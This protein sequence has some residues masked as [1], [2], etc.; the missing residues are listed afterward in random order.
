MAIHTETSSESFSS[1]TRDS[2]QEFESATNAGIQEF[3][4][5][6]ENRF[7]SDAGA[8]SEMF[9]YHNAE[10]TKNVIRRVEKILSSLDTSPREIALG[11][12]FA[13]AHDTIQTGWINPRSGKGKLASGEFTSIFQRYSGSNE[14]TSFEELSQWMLDYN[15]KNGNQI[16]SDVDIALAKE[17]ITGTIPGFDDEKTL[18]QPE[19][20]QGVSEIT[21]ALA[22]ADL[23]A[24]GMEGP[25][26]LLN[27]G[28]A[29]FREEFFAISKTL[30]DPE[31]RQS[32]TENQKKDIQT[33]MVEWSQFQIAIANGFKVTFEKD[34]LPLLNE[35]K[36]TKLKEIFP[37]FQDEAFNT[38]LQQLENKIHLREMMS[39]EEIV[40]EMYPDLKIQ[41]IQEQQQDRAQ[42]IR[43]TISED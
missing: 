23:G 32:L 43:S 22:L 26:A 8:N 11:K 6:I 36:Q 9:A 38:S 16:F 34:R 37:Y 21:L 24:F 14:Q 15:T 3:L 17:A 31:M 12:L 2:I 41:L 4:T 33:K 27:D 30:R 35:D 10:H 40:S 28:D 5:L 18:I 42:S 20:Q 39:F 29:N 1:T 13:T 25:D 19:I 7:E